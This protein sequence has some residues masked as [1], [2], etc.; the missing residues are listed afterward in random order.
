MIQMSS[1]TGLP[2]VLRDFVNLVLAGSIPHA[3]HHAFFGATLHVLKNKDI[4]LRPIAV[5][6]RPK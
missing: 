2:A 3:V 1:P 6:Y 5:T 4:G